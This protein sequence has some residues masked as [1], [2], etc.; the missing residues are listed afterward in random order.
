MRQHRIYSSEPLR[1]GTRVTIAGDAAMHVTKVLRLRPGDALV[2]FDGSG[3]DYEA[4]IETLGR[5]RVTVLVGAGRMLDAESPLAITLLQ[6]VCR[7]QRMD[8][9]VQKA[10]ELGV[11]RIEPVLASRSVV[12]IAGD[13][14]GRKQE[15][16]QRIAIAAAEQ[17]GRSRVPAV[18]EPRRLEEALPALT[19]PSARYLLDPDGAAL[20]DL[21]PPASPLVLLVGPEG[22][23]TGEE[24]RLAGGFG[25]RAVRFGPRIMRTET[26]PLAALA[27]LQY[28]AGDLGR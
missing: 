11:A 16:W 4:E 19:A 3:A 23:L 7:G 2:V 13:Q 21:P 28:L 25:F 1:T 26:A 20:R 22:G 10:T 12:R 14:A 24:R 27:I 17:S 15:H 6:G 9:V 8:T 18:A 5:D